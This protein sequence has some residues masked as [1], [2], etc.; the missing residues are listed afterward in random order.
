MYI[1]ENNLNIGI[2]VSIPNDSCFS[3][4][5]G[6]IL[7]N[8]NKLWYYDSEKEYSMKRVGLFQI[9]LF[10][11]NDNYVATNLI[12]CPRKLPEIDKISR[13]FFEGK[14]ALSNLLNIPYNDIKNTSYGFDEIKYS[15]FGHYK[16]ASI[17]AFH[18]IQKKSPH[19]KHT[20]YFLKDDKN[21]KYTEVSDDLVKLL[22]NGI[23]GDENIKFPIDG[24]TIKRICDLVRDFNPYEVFESYKI[25]IEHEHVNRV[26]RDD[27]FHE[28][29]SYSIKYL[30]DYLKKWFCEK[31]I[32]L[33]F[34]SG[35]TSSFTPTI[36]YE[37]FY[38][39]EN[40]AKAKAYQQYS[41]AEHLDCLLK[42][43][44]IDIFMYQ[45]KLESQTVEYAKYEWLPNSIMI[46]AVYKWIQKTDKIIYINSKEHIKRF[47]K[48]LLEKNIP[49][50]NR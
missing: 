38:K 33:A 19:D 12:P 3:D 47:Y 49:D 22:D 43:H 39:E 10:I 1:K 41:K 5:W 46:E 34:D 48:D 24:K 17:S 7:D 13:L 36:P 35:Y 23:Q 4:I 37:R 9:V 20:R 16:L 21:E 15:N 28:Y 40:E 30:D 42:K 26:G 29:K 45:K 6:L 11:K 27:Y 25:E 2:G 8:T 32:E 14:G 18:Y 31:K 44:Y 50:F